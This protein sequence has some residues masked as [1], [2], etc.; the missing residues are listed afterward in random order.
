MNIY[1]AYIHDDY[2]CS[3]ILGVFVSLKSASD[4]VRSLDGIR[5]LTNEEYEEYDDGWACSANTMEAYFG[6]DDALIRILRR[7]LQP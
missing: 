7:R 6:G 2:E 1:L 4:F 3:E 5:P